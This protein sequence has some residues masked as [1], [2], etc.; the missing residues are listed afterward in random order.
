MYLK[1]LYE[2]LNKST[3]DKSDNYTA[4]TSYLNDATIAEL[5]SLTT[6][7]QLECKLNNLL[8]PQED[9]EQNITSFS[10]HDLQTTLHVK[11]L[12]LKMGATEG[13][14]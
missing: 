10:I 14:T 6:E 9:K 3:T 7:E 1:E 13:N 5:T 8:N 11:K 2:R 4:N 12:S